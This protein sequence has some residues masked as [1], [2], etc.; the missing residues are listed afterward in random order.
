MVALDGTNRYEGLTKRPA[1]RRR[2]GLMT[3]LI[4]KLRKWL[5][6]GKKT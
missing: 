4:D 3:N 1:K 5:G 2:L 6:M